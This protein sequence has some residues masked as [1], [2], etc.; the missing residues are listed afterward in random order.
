MKIDVLQRPEP[1]WGSCAG[2][3]QWGGPGWQ[4]EGEWEDDTGEDDIVVV[5][6]EWPEFASVLATLLE[7]EKDEEENY[8]ETFRVFSK[9]DEGCIPAQEMKFILSQICSME[10]GQPIL[11]FTYWEPHQSNLYFIIG[12]DNEYW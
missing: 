12:N 6:V 7:A 5:K 2:H 11:K 10:V 9:D 3:H 1:Q 4:W 8:K